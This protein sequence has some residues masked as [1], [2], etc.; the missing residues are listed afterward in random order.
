MLLVVALRVL[1][2]SNSLA[3]VVLPFCECRAFVA[4]ID[5]SVHVGCLRKSPE[6]CFQRYGY[7]KSLSFQLIC[8]DVVVVVYVTM[9]MMVKLAV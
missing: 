3:G 7:Q 2:V 4:V 1:K 8:Q 6:W 9:V 5:R